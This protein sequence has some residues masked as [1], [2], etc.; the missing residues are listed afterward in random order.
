MRFRKAVVGE[1]IDLVVDLPCRLLIDAIALHPDHQL[2]ADG[3]HPLAAP[4]VPHRPPQFVGLAGSEAGAGDRDLHPL[5][6]KER[7]T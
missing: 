2:L 3:G 7:N 6:L 1:R 5:F 4:L